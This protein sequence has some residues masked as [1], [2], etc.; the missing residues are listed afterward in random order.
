MEAELRD[1]L[2]AWQGGKLPTGRADALLEQL[3]SDAE[4]RCAFA[5]EVW[6]LSLTRVAQA[7][8][9]RWLA[10]Q[11]ELGISATIRDATDDAGREGALLNEIRKEPLRFVEAWWRWAAYGA[12]ATA[13]VL[14]LAFAIWVGHVPENR[15]AVKSGTLAVL[16]QAEEARWKGGDLAP[17]SAL[18]PGRFHLTSGRASILYPSGVA[19]ELE[20]PA[21]IELLTA[22]RMVCHDGRLRTKVPPGAEGFCVETPGGTVT[23]LGTE[24]GVSVSKDGKTKVAVFEGI[25]EVAVPIPGQDGVRTALLAERQSAEFV[26][27]TGEIRS[28]SPDAFLGESSLRLPVLPLTSTYRD[29]VIAAAPLNYWRLNQASNGRIPNEIAR[30]PALRVA[31]GAKITPDE[32]GRHSAQF[33]GKSAPGALYLDG[34]WMKP[35]KGHAIELWFASQS[36]DIMALAALTVADTY[37]NHIALVELSIRRPGGSAESGIARYLSRWPASM[38]G[39]VNLY[40]PPKAF[41][42]QW[43]HLVAQEKAGQMELFIDGE[44]MGRAKAAQYAPEVRCAVQFGCLEVLKEGSDAA[45]FERPFAGRLAEIALYGRVLTPE[46]IRQHAA[47]GGLQLALRK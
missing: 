47:L 24:L 41:P 33:A 25:A 16:V 7:P 31:G 10:L 45:R 32:F 2:I 37:K 28:E 11:E 40:S 43:H 42:F 3:R 46:E 44:S 23:D 20:G 18:S 9:P 15:A 8:D 19:V 22:D 21:D 39:G 27:G 5:D 36:T 17:G 13:A 29:A 6:T 4:F 1:A 26:A 12:M 30:G 34:A 14:A 35:A 38:R